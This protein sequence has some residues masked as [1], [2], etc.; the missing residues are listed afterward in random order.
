MKS[1]RCNSVTLFYFMLEDARFIKSVFR[2]DDL[3]KNNFPEIIL[4]GRSNVGKSSFINSLL[5][6][7]NLAKTSSTPG[8]TRSINYYLIDNKFYFVDLPGF[9]YAKTSRKERELWGKLINDYL[10]KS[11]NIVLSFHLIDSRHKPTDLD[12]MLY[13]FITRL[14]IPYIIIL[15]KIDKLNQSEIH[16]SVK[17]IKNE[18]Q[19][20][21]L[22]K[23]LFLYSSIK[24]FGKKE[25]LKILPEYVDK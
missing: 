23:N 1:N 16:S 2:L 6:R 9:G 13:N 5:N 21:D 25:I 12:L 15:T 11:K 24:H 14:K 7:K 22:K 19:E 3:P 20:L 17:N 4:C 8:K 18:I 10:Q